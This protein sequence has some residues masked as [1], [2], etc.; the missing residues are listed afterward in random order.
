MDDY[1]VKMERELIAEDIYDWFAI[2]FKVAANSRKAGDYEKGILA[3]LVYSLNSCRAI[4]DNEMANLLDI[5]I[6]KFPIKRAEDH[7]VY[8]FQ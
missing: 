4:T 7:N 2:V 6:F 5:L 8:T 1:D 3:G